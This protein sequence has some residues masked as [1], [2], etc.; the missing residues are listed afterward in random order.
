MATAVR[1]RQ[2][3]DEEQARF[4][5]GHTFDGG[6][7]NSS[8]VISELIEFSSHCIADPRS[9]VPAISFGLG[10]S[11]LTLTST[12]FRVAL[13]YGQIWCARS[14]TCRACA[15]SRSCRRIPS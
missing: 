11:T 5:A 4:P 7:C 2:V 10:Q 13:E 14:T 6:G 1:T 9:R 3:R 12:L 8:R 15:G